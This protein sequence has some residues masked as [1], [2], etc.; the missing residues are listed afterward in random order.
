MAARRL[1]GVNT[2]AGDLLEGDCADWSCVAR[3]VQKR[4]RNRVHLVDE[5]T[6]SQTKRIV[7]GN[8]AIVGFQQV[9]NGGGYY[10]ARCARGCSP[11]VD[12]WRADWVAKFVTGP[13]ASWKKRF[14]IRSVTKYSVD[15]I[16]V[17]YRAA[18][19]ARRLP[20]IN[21]SGRASERGGIINLVDRRQFSLSRCERPPFSS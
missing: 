2:P 7:E 18:D 6:S 1:A 20:V 8:D 15:N 12:D 10:A 3:A 16:H 13:V 17:E 11:H 19:R 4:V 5:T 14:A 21:Y 9:R